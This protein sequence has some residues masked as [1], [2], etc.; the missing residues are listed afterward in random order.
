MD[1]VDPLGK[2]V[3]NYQV[4]CKF[5][6]GADF[7]NDQ[8][9]SAMMKRHG[10]INKDPNRTP[11]PRAYRPLSAGNDMSGLSFEDVEARLKRKIYEAYGDVRAAFKAADGN[12]SGQISI[13]EL[14]AIFRRFQFKLDDKVRAVD[15]VCRRQS[16]L[17][18][19]VS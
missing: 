5:F 1:R 4:A 2:G 6:K 8:Q 14:K 17:D 3:V 7:L 9:V 10:H 11:T 13:G 18:F 12:S 15:F 19:L 16:S